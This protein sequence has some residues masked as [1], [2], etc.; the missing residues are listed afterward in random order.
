VPVTVT[1]LQFLLAV[2][3]VAGST[4]VVVNRVYSTV[5]GSNDA[6][7]ARLEHELD[8]YRQK[9]GDASLAQVAVEVS[10]SVSKSE[11][12]IAAPP[13]EE[14]KPVRQGLPALTASQ[15]SEWSNRLSQHG[16]RALYLRSLEHCSDEVQK[17]LAELF[18]KAG[19]SNTVVGNVS[20]SPL[21]TISSRGA[22]GAALVLV[23]L[24]K[25]LGA[26]VDHREFPQILPG[27]TAIWITVGSK[28]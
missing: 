9:L 6:H 25:S 23:D 28:G 10:N 4:W 15:I 3:I 21:T 19:W 2:L 11:D 18:H 13:D 16:V 7:I 20:P 8:D 22:N 17:S 5:L 27:H 12:R 24:F 26:P 1:L 14:D